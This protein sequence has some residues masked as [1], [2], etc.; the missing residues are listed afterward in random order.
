MVDKGRS[1]RTFSVG[2]AVYLKLKGPHLKSLALGLISKLSSRY[3]GPFP[4][5]AKMG[6]VPYTL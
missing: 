4:I 3:F 2:E 6:N 5:V 1:E